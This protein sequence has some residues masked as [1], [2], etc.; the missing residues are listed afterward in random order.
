M[1]VTRT[2]GHPPH[3]YQVPLVEDSVNYDIGNNSKLVD[4]MKAR[5]SDFFTNPELSGVSEEEFT[6]IVNFKEG[7]EFKEDIRQSKLG[8]VIMEFD[9]LINNEENVVELNVGEAIQTLKNEDMEPEYGSSF[10]VDNGKGKRLYFTLLNMAEEGGTE[11]FKHRIPMKD[12]FK[13]DKRTKHYYGTLVLHNGNEDYQERHKLLGIYYSPEGLFILA[14]YSINGR[15][16][17]SW[18]NLLDRDVFIVDDRK[19]FKEFLKIIIREQ[20]GYYKMVYFN[21]YGEAMGG[22]FP[23]YLKLNPL[24]N[25]VNHKSM[26]YE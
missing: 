21:N 17:D 22:Q 6:N 10:Y 12:R 2:I 13:E 1:R 11:L 23:K 14:R 5:V 3:D 8:C 18:I 26:L 24:T 20:S 19:D 7:R 15:Y 25:R 9:R 16:I 4:E